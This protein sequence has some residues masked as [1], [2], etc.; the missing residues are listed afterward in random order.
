MKKIKSIIVGAIIGSSLL[1]V[2]AS[3][4][5]IISTTFDYNL[6]GWSSN[7]PSEISWQSTGGNPGGYIRFADSSSAESL[8]YA[9]ASYLG[10]W[11]SIN[12]LGTISFD[13]K[14]FNIGSNPTSIPYQIGISGLGG[15]AI[16]EHNNPGSS[17]DWQ[18]L[19][20]SIT[21]ADWTVLS[22]SWNSLLHD[23][24]QLSI[25]IE[26]ISNA[27]PGSPSV[28]EITGIDNVQLTNPVPIPGTVWLLGSGIAGLVSSRIRR[29]KQ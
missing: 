23:V 17:T 28:F 24:V 3:W 15:E 26:V 10:N 16:W 25:K 29:K 11:S 4:A 9:P 21:E 7:T 18:T 20:A 6:Q 8:I 1:S 12:G 2:P 27:G 5:G 13:H 22:G 19:S 14:I